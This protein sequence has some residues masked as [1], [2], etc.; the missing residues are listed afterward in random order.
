VYQKILIPLDGSD[1]SECSLQHVKAIAQGCNVPDVIVFRVIVPLSA[2][3]ISAL[4]T[5][6]DD[7]LRRAVEQNEQDAKDYVLKVRDS[8]QTQAVSSRAVTVQGRAADEILSYAE[9]TN[10][11]L[12]VMSTHGRSGL[13]RFFYGSV[14]EKVVRHS[15]I[16]VLLVAPEGCRTI[17]S[18]K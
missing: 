5:V 15:R 1:L 7:S 10:V 8:L 4:A 17:P 13:S 14:A 16:P 12:I 6:G 3:A 2:E 11:D 18:T 9:K